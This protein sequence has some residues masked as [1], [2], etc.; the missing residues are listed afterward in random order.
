MP[1]R[2]KPWEAGK[3]D[4][5]LGWK[6]FDEQRYPEAEQL[7]RQ[8]AQEREKVLGKEHVDTLY[9]KYELGLTLYKQQKYPEAKQLFRQS[10]QE[11]EKILG[12]EHVDTL[13]SK[14]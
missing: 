4:L 13:F 8:S 5:E 2:P 6:L 7:F 11:R 12:K 3:K 14:L 1:S 10:V 9:S